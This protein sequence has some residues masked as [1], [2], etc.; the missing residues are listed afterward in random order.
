[1]KSF[2]RGATP[3]D[4]AYSIHTE[5]GHQCVGARVNGK[6]VPLRSKLKNGDIVE[7]LTAAGHT[8]SRDWLTSTVTNKARAK[9]RHYLNVAEKQQA[10]EL[11]KKHFERDLKRYHISLK[12]LAANPKV[13]AVAQEMGF[14]TK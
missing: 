5:V 7:I 12:K 8:P 9:I 4:F 2:P 6:I 11:G 3:V 1:V 13:E 10:L 14:G